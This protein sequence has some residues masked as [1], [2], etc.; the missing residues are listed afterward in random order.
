MLTA[1]EKFFIASKRQKARIDSERKRREK[2]EAKFHSGGGWDLAQVPEGCLTLKQAAEKYNRAPSG[3]HKAI[4]IGM[5]DS[6]KIGPYRVIRESDLLVYFDEAARLKREAAYRAM[7]A[8]REKLARLKKV[9]NL[10]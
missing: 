8:R 9:N 5:L 6:Q 4:A 7:C 10:V 1:R 2:K 3:I